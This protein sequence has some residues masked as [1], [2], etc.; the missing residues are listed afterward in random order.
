MRAVPDMFSAAPHSS[1]D[2]PADYIDQETRQFAPQPFH[3][4]TLLALAEF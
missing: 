1:L 2:D 4:R 3:R